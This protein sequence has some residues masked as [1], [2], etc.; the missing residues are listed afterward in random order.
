MKGQDPGG[1]GSIRKV[2]FTDFKIG[3]LWLTSASFKINSPHHLIFQK[4]PPFS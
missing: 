4:H 2:L 3:Y 1:G